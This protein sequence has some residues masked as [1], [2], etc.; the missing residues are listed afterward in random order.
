MESFIV[1]NGG[2]MNLYSL[3]TKLNNERTKHSKLVS[4]RKIEMDIIWSNIFFPLFK[5]F[6]ATLVETNGEMI[7]HFGLKAWN[8]A[9]TEFRP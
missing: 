2:K 8:F 6:S 9:Q 3:R 7:V 5:P 4:R 1:K